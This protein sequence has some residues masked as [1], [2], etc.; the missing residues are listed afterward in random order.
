MR[1]PLITACLLAACS[2]GAIAPG[3]PLQSPAHATNSVLGSAAF[4]KRRGQVEI[5]VKANYEEIKK[6]IQAGGGP[7][8]T[9][10]FDTAGV[11]DADRPTRILQLQSDAGLFQTSP[12]A[13]VTAL[14]LYGS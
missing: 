8:L 12:A 13:L 2:Q 7:I 14:M 4:E 6:D 3:N 9:K 5:V 10:A 11:P 1:W